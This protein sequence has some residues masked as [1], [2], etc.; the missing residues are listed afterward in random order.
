MV[1]NEKSNNLQLILFDGYYY[2]DIIPKN[3]EDR[4]KL[5]FAKSAFKRYVINIDLSLLNKT[6]Q[7]E[8]VSTN[9]MLTISQLK[10]TLDSLNRNFKKDKISFADN[11]YL[12]TGITNG[13]LFSNYSDTSTVKKS[14]TIPK[15][16][17]GSFTKTQKIEVLK[18]ALS[19]LENSGYSV[20]SALTDFDNK[21]KNISSHW[22]ALYEKFV[23]AFACLLMFFIGAPLGAI[24]RKGG[25]GLPIVFAVIIFIIYHFTNTF[26][27]RVAQENGMPAFLGAWISTL[28]MSPLAILLTYR[29]IKD[30]GGIM[31]FDA[32]TLAFENLFPKTNSLNKNI[33]DVDQKQ[34]LLIYQKQYQ[35]LSIIA[36]AISIVSFILFLD[37]IKMPTTQKTIFWLLA[38]CV[39]YVT[40]YFSQSK[41]QNI[42][43]IVNRKFDPGK[44]VALILSFPIYFIVY[45][46]NY[47]LVDKAISEYQFVFNQSNKNSDNIEF[48]K[49]NL[50]DSDKIKILLIEHQKMSLLA[51]IT[52]II[53]LITTIFSAINQSQISI[54]ITVILIILLYIMAF[55]TQK[56]VAQ[57]EKIVNQKFDPG[58]IVSLILAFPLYFLVYYLNKKAI[59][60]LKINK[61]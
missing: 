61:H 60:Q 2:E 7:S 44:T 43:T 27:K 24:I 23:I 5:P 54:V 37:M 52:F 26:G 38:N 6:D 1:S 50:I 48:E 29:A 57:I 20:D 45:L 17:L 31:N 49:I 22:I 56:K 33:N 18:V 36:I 16:I 59:S 55:L 51:I 11:S 58:I 3:Y 19:N 21:K 13:T 28:I 15:D 53:A 34:N 14:N 35:T 25:L 42:E 9:S 30:I 4:S 8:V 12:R 46:L 41:L 32:I 47:K 39:L 10:F 40:V